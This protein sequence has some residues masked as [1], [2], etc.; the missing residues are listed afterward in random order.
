MYE[1]ETRFYTPRSHEAR[2]QCLF[3]Q[4]ARKR[5]NS[6]SSTRLSLPPLGL[7]ALPRD[8][9]FYSSTMR[10]ALEARNDAVQP[11]GAWWALMP[12]LIAG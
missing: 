10:T 1:K 6:P 2:S 4:C 5:P 8:R 3:W 9:T 7:A 12:F 11:V